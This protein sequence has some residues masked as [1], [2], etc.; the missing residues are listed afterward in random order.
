MVLETTKVTSECQYSLKVAIWQPDKEGMTQCHK[1]PLREL[2]SS[3]R[4]RNLIRL[5]L[6]RFAPCVTKLSR[7]QSAKNNEEHQNAKISISGMAGG[8]QIP[9]AKQENNG[10]A[11]TRKKSRFQTG[12]IPHNHK[13]IEMEDLTWHL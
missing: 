6:V 12:Y 13:S 8:G 1:T 11:V 9:T 3:E 4:K 5:V 7:V 2:R 10:L